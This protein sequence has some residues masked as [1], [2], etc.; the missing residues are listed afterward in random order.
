MNPLSNKRKSRNSSYLRK[1]VG[2][3]CWKLLGKKNLSSRIV[4]LKWNK[5]GLL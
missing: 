5:A 1:E 4:L 3:T 2:R